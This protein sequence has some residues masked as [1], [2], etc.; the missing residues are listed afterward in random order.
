[1]QAVCAE[2]TGE[3]SGPIPS[4]GWGLGVGKGRGGHQ[5][6]IPRGGVCVVRCTCVHRVKRAIQRLFFRGHASDKSRG[7]GV[8][9]A[10]RGTGEDTNLSE[11]GYHFEDLLPIL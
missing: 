10:L 9:C 6:R 3:T 4:G 2:P 5:E 1:M 8:Q 7:K 11:S